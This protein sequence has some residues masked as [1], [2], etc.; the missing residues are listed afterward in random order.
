[1]SISTEERLQRIEQLVVRLHEFC[2]EL[3]EYI[4][5]TDESYRGELSFHLRRDEESLRDLRHEVNHRD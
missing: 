1:M 3:E 2:H 5:K 4:R